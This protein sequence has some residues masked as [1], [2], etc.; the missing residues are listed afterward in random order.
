MCAF[1]ILLPIDMIYNAGCL[2]LKKEIKISFIGFLFQ[3]YIKLVD[4][5][6]IR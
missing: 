5:C 6:E 2:L 1:W 4:F 3:S